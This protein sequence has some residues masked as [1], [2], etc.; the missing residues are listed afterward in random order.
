MAGIALI[1]IFGLELAVGQ[2]LAARIGQTKVGEV[3]VLPACNVGMA[4]CFLGLR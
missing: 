2:S 3:D 4:D 1:A